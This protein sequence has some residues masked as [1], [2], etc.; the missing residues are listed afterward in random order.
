VATRAS[1]GPPGK[2]GPTGKAGPTGKTAGRRT[3][4]LDPDELADLEEQRDF[5]LRS[6]ADLEAEHDA[7]DLDD[8]DYAELRD[9]YTVRA[10]EVIRAIDDQRAA[11]AAARAP[12]NPGRT[13]AATAGVVV[14]A[15]IAGLLVARSL[16][17]REPGDTLTGGIDVEQSASQRA[18]QCIPA[19]DPFAPS[20]SIECFQA[21]LDDDPRNPV[22]LTWLGWQLGLS[23]AFIEDP[24]Q[25]ADL[26]GS[27]AQL[28][29]RAIEVNPSYSY[30]RAFRAVLAFRRGDYAD[31]QRY[32]EEFEAND[33][34]PDA[35][36]VIEAEDLEARIA[37]ALAAEQGEEPEGGGSDGDAPAPTSEPAGG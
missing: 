11:F 29:D 13:V 34:S 20:E 14:F 23:A 30:A 2:V 10:A 7:G 18:Q 26:E 8:D 24:D 35:R 15:L 21:V 27:A 22:A 33:P 12:R 6:L 36:Q 3:K 9:D 32:L 19:I 28:V 4:R 37:E 25:A 31:A 16:G 1:A 17:A 5:L